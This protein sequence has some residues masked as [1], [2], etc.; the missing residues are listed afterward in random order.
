MKILYAIQATGNGHLSRANDIIPILQ[1]KADLDILLSGNQA[2]VHF[3]FNIKYHTKGVSFI[4]GKKGGVDIW[5]T[6]IKIN[7]RNIFTEIHNFPI[8]NY[9]LIIN[10]FEPISAWAAKLRNIPCIS[11]SHQAAVL[12]KKAPK[13]KKTD[14]FG[15]QILR[16]Y[17]PIK[18][19]YGFHFNNYDEHIYTPVIRNQVRMQNVKNK[20]HYTVYLPAYGDKM[21]IKILS[22]L[23]NATWDVFSK[24]AEQTY[25]KNNVFISP[26]NNNDFIKSMATSTGILCGAGFETPAEALFLGKKLMVIPM[27]LQYEQQCNAAALK[28]MGI[29]V[30]KN[31]NKKNLPKIEKWLNDHTRI[32]VNYPNN[33]EKIINKLLNLSL[34]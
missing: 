20:G 31:L 10:D 17:A 22:R 2:D 8:D 24:H 6:L 21:I 11:L 9:D 5:K 1:E 3:P 7:F 28:Q 14:W 12:N 18:N 30:L 29:P 27:K 26:I 19:N 33:T 32:C 13:P 25:Q 16:H 23:K 4:F 15:K 34:N